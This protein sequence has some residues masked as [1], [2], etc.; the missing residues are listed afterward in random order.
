M[1]QQL[2]LAIQLSDEAT[3]EDFHWGHNLLLQQHVQTL[4]GPGEM[5]HL[6]YVWG[7]PGCGKSHL[8][9]ACCH[10]LHRTKAIYLPLPILKEFSPQLL[11]GLEEHALICIDD[12]DAIEGLSAWE[13]ALF[14]LYNRIRENA[15]STLII[16][17]RTTPINSPI[18]LADLKSRLGW[19][20]IVQLDELSDE[21]KIKTLQHHAQKRGFELPTSVV[22]FLMSRCARNM[23]DLHQ[24]LNQLDETSLA[25]HRKIT[26]PF[27]KQALGL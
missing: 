18:R 10:A 9:Q 22:Q 5:K 2:A 8:L 4:L 12:I 6:L 16:S 19:G 21:D 27:A 7:P 1:N 25:A 26:I 15:H 11:E 3:L 13:E 20:L 14:H 17:G 24:L 23:H